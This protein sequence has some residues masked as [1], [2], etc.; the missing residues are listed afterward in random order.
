MIKLGVIGLGSI[1]QTQLKALN[2]LTDEYQLTAVYDKAPEKREWFDR[3]IQ[4]ALPALP[5]R[6]MI[7]HLSCM[8]I[9]KSKPF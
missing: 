4:P 9:L 1:F 8:R 6:Y 7:L 3:T 5:Q 2:I